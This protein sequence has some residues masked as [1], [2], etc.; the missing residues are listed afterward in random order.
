METKIFEQEM[1][2]RLREQ[3]ELHPVMKQEDTV[4]F[5]FQAMLGPGHILSSRE[6]VEAYI[7]RE[8]DGLPEDPGEPLFEIL[9]PDWCRLN[10]RR[11]K[12]EQIPPSV[13]AGLMIS[14]PGGRA[15]SR[16]DVYDTCVRLAE[17]GETAIPDIDS[18]RSILD[19]SRLPSHSAAYR[20]AEHPAYRVVSTE[21]VPCAEVIRRLVKSQANIRRLLVTIDGPCAS[22]KTTLAER[23]A[24]V[25]DAAVVIRM[26]S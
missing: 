7:A 25:F 10:L 12:A 26:I 4:K 9:S 11:A 8:M 19:E 22:G 13:I 24:Q 18:L 14:I 15:F 21:W 3:R 6:K 16:Q 1:M 5:V 23:L 2:D 20:E 17:S